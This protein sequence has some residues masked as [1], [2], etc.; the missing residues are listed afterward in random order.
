VPV[1][2]P[3]T[4]KPGQPPLQ[5]AAGVLTCAGPTGPLSWGAGGSGGAIGTRLAFASPAG[6]SAAAPAGFTSAIGR[7]IV[8][9]PG[10]NATWPTL[11][12]GQ[13][14][15]LLVIVNE[16]AANTLTL[17]AATWGGVG[18]LVLGPKARVMTY[19]DGS[20]GTPNWKVT[21]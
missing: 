13:D 15:Q 20:A 1:S 8:T 11:T 2:T 21:Q 7:L 18:D 10:G 9:L 3:P 14:G 6:V 19:Y 12:A 4:F 5:L 16:D 17:P